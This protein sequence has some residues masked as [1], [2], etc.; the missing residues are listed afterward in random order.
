MDGTGSS[1]DDNP[2]I[3]VG[4]DLFRVPA[5]RVLDLAALA[6]RITATLA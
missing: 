2:V 4:D 6:A 1:A 5:R 3:E